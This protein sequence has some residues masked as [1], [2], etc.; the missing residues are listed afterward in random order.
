M[1]LSAYV[2]K[3]IQRG[4]R[5]RHAAFEM[6]SGKTYTYRINGSSEGVVVYGRHEF[7]QTRTWLAAPVV[8]I[9]CLASLIGTAGNALILTVICSNKL[10]RNVTT[11]FIMNLAIS[12]LYVTL[13][14][15]P[16]SIIGRLFT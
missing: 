3:G 5:H 14:A 13:V 8:S 16:M 12:D 2:H 6:D 7:I 11:M 1:S 10:G 9:I 15:D 4:E